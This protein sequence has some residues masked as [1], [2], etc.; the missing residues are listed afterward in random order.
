M[1]SLPHS[2]VISLTVKRS[3][4][5]A[6]FGAVVLASP[7][8]P[9]YAQHDTGRPAPTRA[10]SQAQTVDQRI[11]NLHTELKITPAE[12]ADWQGVAQTMRDNA[13]AMQK[14]AAE[15]SSQSQQGMTAV[16]DLQTYAQF[17]QVR[18]DGLK[19]LISSFQTLYNS[20]PDQQ[21]KLADQVFLNS[22]R[23][24]ASRHG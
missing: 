18:V 15:K 7:L 22:R 2:A 10:A 23:Q 14:L 9:A 11:D 3:A 21:K 8:V 17:A 20:M 5:A 12:E 1:S 16:E 13:A 6:L 4:A 19:N 24:E